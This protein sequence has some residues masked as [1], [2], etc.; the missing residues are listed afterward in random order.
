MKALIEFDLYEDTQAFEDFLNS[1]D[2]SDKADDVWDKV[3]RPNFKHGYHR[4]INDIIKKC[5]KTIDEDGEE[6]Y[7]GTEL[8][9]K[10]SEIYLEIVNKKTKK[11]RFQK[12]RISTLAVLMLILTSFW[13]GYAV[14]FIV[15]TIRAFML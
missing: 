14:N 6:R 12:G 4:E 2:S 9:E 7:N 8:I 15:T 10:L 3:F 1:R 13:A 5:G 11:P